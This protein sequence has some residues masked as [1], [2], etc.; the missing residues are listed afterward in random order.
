MRRS[1]HAND[2]IE[3][4]FAIIESVID[5][6]SV[7]SLRS[8]ADSRRVHEDLYLFGTDLFGS[9]P[10]LVLPLVA[11]PRVLDI[12]EEI[13]GPFVQLDSFSVVGI[14]AGCPADISWHRDPYGGVPQGHEF[15]RPMAMNLLIYL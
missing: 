5:A 14:A 8:L 13:M 15:L 4:G 7:A 12:A 6:Q 10:E 1:A 9:H 2:I 11:A 3:N